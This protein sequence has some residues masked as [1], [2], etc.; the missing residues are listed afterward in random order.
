[1]NGYR[2][3]NTEGI[4]NLGKGA[5]KSVRASVHQMLGTITEGHVRIAQIS[6]GVA[7]AKEREERYRAAD[8]ASKDAHRIVGR[9]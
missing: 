7:N 8:N 9:G 4:Q 2:V 6:A 1:M 3:T 5:L